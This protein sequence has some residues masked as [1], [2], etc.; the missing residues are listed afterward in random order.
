M[1]VCMSVYTFVYLGMCVHAGG[2]TCVF[3]W[4]CM[5]MYLGV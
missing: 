2:Y 3:E 5:S 1:Y 4:E